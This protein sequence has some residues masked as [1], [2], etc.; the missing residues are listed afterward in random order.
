M[1]EQFSLGLSSGSLRRLDIERGTTEDGRQYCWGYWDTYANSLKPEFNTMLTGYIRRIGVRQTEYKSK[2]SNQLLIEVLAGPT[3]YRIKAGLESAAGKNLVCAIAVLTQERL[4]KPVSIR[5]RP[6]DDDK[7]VLVTLFQGDEMVRGLPWPGDVTALRTAYKRAKQ[8][9][10]VM[11][12]DEN[13]RV[14]RN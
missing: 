7:V 9:L 5:V 11:Q 12:F 6:G 10:E 14:I 4:A 8:H 1:A 13:G 2:K 3:S